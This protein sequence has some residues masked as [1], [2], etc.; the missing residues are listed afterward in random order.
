MNFKVYM[1]D[2]LINEGCFTSPEELLNGVLSRYS[3]IVR[4]IEKKRLERKY[5]RLT[6]DDIVNHYK[7][8]IRIEIE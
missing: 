2:E 3:T 5:G 1:K 7:Q 8:S 6:V 4:D